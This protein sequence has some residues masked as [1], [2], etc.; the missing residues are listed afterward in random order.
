M[1]RKNILGNSFL[2]LDLE[3]D[4]EKEFK[5][6][7]KDKDMT[8]KQFVRFLIREYIKKNGNGKATD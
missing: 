2:G 8:G 3:D 5:R 6:I 1:A 7:I 4:Q